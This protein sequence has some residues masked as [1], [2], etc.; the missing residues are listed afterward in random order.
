MV[1]CSV[2]LFLCHTWKLDSDTDWP[3]RL[4]S[5]GTGQEILGEK[6]PLPREAT[7]ACCA[8]RPPDSKGNGIKEFAEP[9]ALSS[10]EPTDLPL[11]RT[12]S[13]LGF[14]LLTLRARRSFAI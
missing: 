10:P 9:V 3:R 7:A 12:A 5:S 8:W 14:D 1:V 2:E 13:Q 4:P 11:A 6:Q